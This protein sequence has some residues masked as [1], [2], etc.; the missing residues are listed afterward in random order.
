[1]NQIF[2]RDDFAP[3]LSEVRQMVVNGPF[4]TERGPD[5]AIYT[6][7]SEYP[8]PH[9]YDLISRLRGKNIV[10]KLSCFRLNLAGELPHSWVH[11]DDICARYASVLYLNTPEQCQGGTAFWKHV[12]LDA[13]HLL[14]EK[15][16]LERGLNKDLYLCGMSRDWKDLSL[17]KQVDL[18]PMRWNRFVTYPTC[19]FHSRFPFEAFGKGP[20][21]GRL[22][23]ICFYDLEGES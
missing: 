4:S 21:D 5:G 9:W 16:L 8:V 15:E 7:I 22:I 23:W 19:L 20:E 6:G 10:P 18:V 12:L 1:M 14:N 17:W 11:S 3:D 13:D 2:V